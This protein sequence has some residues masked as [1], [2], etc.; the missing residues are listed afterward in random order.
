ML[1][2]NL[3]NLVHIPSFVVSVHH[4]RLYHQCYVVLLSVV[5]P[6]YIHFHNIRHQALLLQSFPHVVFSLLSA[7]HTLC[8]HTFSHNGQTSSSSIFTKR[9]SILYYPTASRKFISFS[10]AARYVLIFIT[11]PLFYSVPTYVLQ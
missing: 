10:I 8:I 3:L 2:T 1:F 4:V 6:R 7:S 9:L 11:R 5:S